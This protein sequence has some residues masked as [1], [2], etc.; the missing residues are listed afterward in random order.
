MRLWE[1]L[2]W[3]VRRQRVVCDSL[4]KTLTKD[5]F[6]VLSSAATYIWIGIL[7]KGS[8]YSEGLFERI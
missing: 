5:L 2:G 7:I 1:K 6:I 8:S 4:Y 3:F